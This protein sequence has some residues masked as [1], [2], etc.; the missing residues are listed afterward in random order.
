MCPRNFLLII[1]FHKPS[2]WRFINILCIV[3]QLCVLIV[4]SVYFP[5]NHFFKKV[6]WKVYISLSYNSI[7][8]N[9][10]FAAEFAVRF[11]V[12]NAHWSNQRLRVYTQGEATGQRPGHCLHQQALQKARQLQLSETGD[13]LRNC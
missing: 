10:I 3:V 6:K 9:D 5:S 1:N 13:V 8:L 2:V 11:A 4:Q 12:L 7:H